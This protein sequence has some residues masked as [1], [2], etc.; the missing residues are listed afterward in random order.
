V[1]KGGAVQV[2]LI[3][4]DP[5]VR[6]SIAKILERGGFTV[7]PVANGLTALSELRDRRF[8]AIVTDVRLPF[9]GGDDFFRQVQQLFPDLTKRVVFVTG[10]AQD[11]SV[12]EFLQQTGQPCLAKPFE[13]AELIAAV[14]R[15]AAKV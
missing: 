7:L 1:A 14:Q 9:L 6:A 13:A 11:Q 5:L 15:V 3:E 10:W 12:S 8:A 4:D 2:L